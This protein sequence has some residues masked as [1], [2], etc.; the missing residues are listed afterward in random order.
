MPDKRFLAAKA[1]ISALNQRGLSL[2]TC[3]SLTAGLVCASLAEVPGASTVLRGGLVTYATQLKQ[4]L[5]GVDE[6]QLAAHGPIHPETARQMAVGAKDRC[7][8][9]IGVGLTGVAGPDPQDGHPVGEI[10]I[11][12][13]S[14]KQSEVEQVVVD[15]HLPEGSRQQLRDLAV[16]KVF[17][18]LLRFVGDGR[19]QSATGSR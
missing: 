19:E 3:E 18:L 9:D 11:A 1:V 16:I 5:A 6:N 15:G 17:E 13:A 2:A 4:K 10:Y 7:G 14:S 12:V 8:A